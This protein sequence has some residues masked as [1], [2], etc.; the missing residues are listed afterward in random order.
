M[1]H[2]EG[3]NTEGLI[4]E[5]NK[6]WVIN[7]SLRKFFLG[8]AQ[9]TETV[10]Q[11]PDQDYLRLLNH[12]QEMIEH[13]HNANSYIIRHFLSKCLSK[14][15]SIGHLFMEKMEN[16]LVSNKF[17]INGDTRELVFFGEQKPYLKNAELMNPLLKSEKKPSI[18]KVRGKL[19]NALNNFS[20]GTRSIFFDSLFAEKERNDFVSTR[21]FNEL[22]K[23][24]IEIV[25][26]TDHWLTEAGPFRKNCSNSEPILRGNA[27]VMSIGLINIQ[28][29]NPRTHLRESKYLQEYIR[30]MG[31]SYGY[32]KNSFWKIDYFDDGRGILRNLK[33]YSN[34][35][36][37]TLIEAI[38]KNMSSR[39][40]DGN[41]LGFER[42]FKLASSLKGYLSI[43][44]GGRTVLK[45]EGTQR[46]REVISKEDIDHGTHIQ[47]VFPSKDIS[48]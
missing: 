7:K 19:K 5:M 38:D 9:F 43:S 16:E 40:G 32:T 30:T 15:S 35:N 41:G 27:F 26:N 20:Q 1:V 29:R 28:N 23:F 4:K 18:L 24:H 46:K 13:K 10:R 8:Y 2:Q 22:S 47:L 33:M 37:L 39:K 6:P 11:S 34:H 45:V 31:S 44:S 42:M 17:I 3:I 48:L 25:D 36:P 21:L 12:Y 14:T